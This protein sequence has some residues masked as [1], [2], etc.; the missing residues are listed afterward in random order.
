[1]YCQ[2][3]L[4]A[5]YAFDPDNL[6]VLGDGASGDVWRARDRGTW[7]TVA[8]KQIAD[9]AVARDCLELQSRTPVI[10]GI[11]RVEKIFTD[12]PGILSLVMPIAQG[13]DLDRTTGIT[14]RELAFIVRRVLY[15]LTQLH[16]C[17]IVHG[18]IKPENIIWCRATRT[19]SLI[20]HDYWRLAAVPVTSD[21][22]STEAYF[23]PDTNITASGV[24]AGCEIDIWSLGVT[25]Y[26][27]LE[28]DFPHGT[29]VFTN[30]TN[31]LTQDFIRRALAPKAS[32]ATAAQ[33][34]S[35][36]FIA[37]SRSSSA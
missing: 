13:M 20:D 22:V 16:S 9:S 3:S 27:L 12:T 32:R 24:I 26:A 28:N 31:P 34:L 6:D 4:E 17:G 7:R 10:N 33:L 1:M 18:D 36:P 14:E 2:G 37:R 8:I 5:A 25:V 21:I 15:I 23:P 11:I 19:A 30:I 29:L 35:H